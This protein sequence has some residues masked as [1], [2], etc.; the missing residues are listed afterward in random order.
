MDRIWKKYGLDIKLGA[1]M[2]RYADD[3]VVMCRKGTKKPMEVIQRILNRLGLSLSP[4]KTRELDSRKD[5]F[6]FLGFEIGMKKSIRTGNPYPH[7]EP[8]K[9]AL[10][11]IRQRITYLTRREM[12]CVPLEAMMEKVNQVLQG[13]VEYFHYRN[14]SRALG[15]LKWH[16]EERM[17]TQLRKRHKI[18]YRVTG[19]ERF[20]TRKLYEQY[21]L[22]KVPTTAGWTTA[23]ALR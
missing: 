14:C 21:G 17:R 10:G 8:S 12:T 11:M 15:K 2:V 20:S 6:R 23:H 19:Y 9:E 1:R 16:I 4:T 13:W 7:V 22:Y 18:R 5:S 3:F